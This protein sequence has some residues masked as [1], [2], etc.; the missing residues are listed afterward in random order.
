MAMSTLHELSRA[1]EQVEKKLAETQSSNVTSDMKD[2]QIASSSKVSFLFICCSKISKFLTT[3]L[4]QTKNND[5][6]VIIDDDD[7]EKEID[8]FLS[9]TAGN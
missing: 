2:L 8:T 5:D 9:Q 1:K 3:F 6:P 7:T 4:P